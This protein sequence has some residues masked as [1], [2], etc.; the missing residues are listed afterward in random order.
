MIGIGTLE[1]V[2]TIFEEVDKSS[3]CTADT[4]YIVCSIGS[5]GSIGSIGLAGILGIAGIVVTFCQFPTCRS[6]ACSRSCPPYWSTSRWGPRYS[7]S[8]A[9]SWG[10]T[11]PP[12]LSAHTWGAHTDLWGAHLDFC[13]GFANTGSTYL[14][15]YIWIWLC[16]MASPILAAHIWRRRPVEIGE[17]KFLAFQLFSSH[18]QHQNKLDNKIKIFFKSFFIRIQGAFWKAMAFLCKTILLCLRWASFW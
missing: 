3:F 18:C 8:S 10:A 11:A 1:K 4:L 15:E 2:G 9:H 16:V 6:P 14:G 12:A 7:R 13:H 5:A 17:T